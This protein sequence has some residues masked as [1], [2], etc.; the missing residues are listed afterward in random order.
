M[1]LTTLKT[2]HTRMALL[3][4]MLSMCCLCT[5]HSGLLAAPTNG[6]KGTVFAVP[7]TSRDGITLLLWGSHLYVRTDPGGA[8]VLPSNKLRPDLLVVRADDG[9]TRGFLTC[10]DNIKEFRES[11]AGGLPGAFAPGPGDDHGKE[12]SGFLRVNAGRAA[13]P[14]GVIDINGSVPIIQAQIMPLGRSGEW[15]SLPYGT[16]LPIGPTD[17]GGSSQ[18]QADLVLHP[19]I[20]TSWVI[21][22]RIDSTSTAFDIAFDLA[23]EGGRESYSRCVSSSGIADGY[24]V[25]LVPF[26]AASRIVSASIQLESCHS[27]QE[28]G[29]PNESPL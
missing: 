6:Q 15:I 13:K 20:E 26:M 24:Q 7:G 5:L 18:C 19:V 27:A 3:A 8:F 11:R 23:T 1:G 9:R 16:V 12:S 2:R 28:E 14:I 22:L 29:D 4:M 10:S 17:S 21:A 25:V